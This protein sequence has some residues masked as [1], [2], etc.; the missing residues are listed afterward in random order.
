MCLP[1]D[2]QQ[3]NSIDFKKK[4][5]GIFKDSLDIESYLAFLKRDENTIKNWGISY[6]LRTYMSRK[7]SILPKI[8]LFEIISKSK[9]LEDN[10]VF[11]DNNE[12]LTEFVTNA[13]NGENINREAVIKDL[14]NGDKKLY[15]SWKNVIDLWINT[16]K[17]QKIKLAETCFNSYVF[18]D[19]LLI[20]HAIF[21]NDPLFHEELTLRKSLRT[22]DRRKFN[23]T[24]NRAVSM[25]AE[26]NIQ[27][28]PHN[29][30]VRCR[31]EAQKFKKIVEYVIEQE[32][33][34]AETEETSDDEYEL[35][36]LSQIKRKLNTN[37][38]ISSS[39]ETRPTKRRKN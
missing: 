39:S 8:I 21:F 30:L 26:N 13:L 9:K 3:L 17:D 10:A 38:S 14:F 31:D 12:G 15:G 7:A 33:E 11:I 19:K 34:S 20:L 25:M 16:T 27:S 24:I 2:L 6:D 36:P 4:L 37:L 28:I 29:H 32:Q 23:D 1:K 22:S 18:R 5:E 35:I